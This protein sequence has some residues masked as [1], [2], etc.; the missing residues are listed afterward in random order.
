MMERKGDTKQKL[1]LDNIFW[2]RRKA[3]KEKVL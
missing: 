1:N 2:I 3:L